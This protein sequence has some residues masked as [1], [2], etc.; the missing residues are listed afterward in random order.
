MCDAYVSTV[1]DADETL[2]NWQLS[3][4]VTRKQCNDG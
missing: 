2:F 4:N 3:N 1:G